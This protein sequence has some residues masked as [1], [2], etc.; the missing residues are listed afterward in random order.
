K[1]QIEIHPCIAYTDFALRRFFET[2]K[3]TDWYNQTLFVITA[4]HT[5]LAHTDFYQSNIGQHRVPI[6]FYKSDGSLKGRPNILAQHTDIM[7]SV[8]DYL[9]IDQSFLAF[10]NS[11]FDSTAMRFGMYYANEMWQFQNDD[12]FLMWDGEKTNAFYDLRV[13]SLLQRNL[14]STPPKE[15]PLIEKRV[16]A[17][18]QSYNTRMLNNKLQAR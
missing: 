5:S 10:G 1:G 4:D 17:I 13:D 2:A 14:I 15:L 16:K 12:Y 3:K 11:V 6:I 9:G 8:V 18:V 7:P